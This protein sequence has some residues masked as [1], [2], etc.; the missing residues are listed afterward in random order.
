MDFLVGE[1]LGTPFVA[2]PGVTSSGLLSS[3]SLDQQTELIYVGYFNRS[4][5]GGGFGFWEGQNTSAQAAGQSA[6]VALTNIAN[7]FT[8]QPE[9]IAAYPFLGSSNVNLS[10]PAVQAQVGTL[11]SNVYQNLFGHAP[12]SGGATYWLGQLTSGAI[13]LGKAVL[14]I[15][16]GATG[17]DAI[18][19]ENKIAVALDFTTRTTAANLTVN[20]ALLAEA[21]TVLAGVDA[22]SLNDASVTSAEALTTAYIA[23]APHASAAGVP[24]VPTVSLVGVADAG[25]HLA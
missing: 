9:T 11:I 25:I 19:L 20:S 15:A 17:P 12:D 14:A 13:P 10:D 24:D 18:I 23:T 6:A 22:V 16:N 7:S 3:L 21:K 8:P 1:V 2:T 5:D 4:A